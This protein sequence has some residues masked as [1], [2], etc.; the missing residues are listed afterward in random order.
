MATEKTNIAVPR[1]HVSGGFDLIGQSWKIFIQKWKKLFWFLLFFP[2][3][4]F[5]VSAAIGA[6]SVWGTQYLE[7][8]SVNAGTDLAIQI[9]M[10]VMYVALIVAAVFFSMVLSAATVYVVAEDLSPKEAFKKGIPVFWRFFGWI[11]LVSIILAIAF[12]LLVVPAIILIVFLWFSV[13]A[14]T[15]EGLGPIKAMGRSF[16]LV[17]GF[18]WT[19]FARF[20]I[21][22]IFVAILSIISEALSSGGDY[23][24]GFMD[25]GTGFLFSSVIIIVLVYVLVF[26]INFIA[27]SIALIYSYLLYK[28]LKEIKS[29]D[30]NSTDRM[31][32]SKKIGLGFIMVAIIALIVIVFVAIAAFTLSG[33]NPN[34]AATST[35]LLLEQNFNNLDQAGS[36]ISQEQMKE[37]LK[38]LETNKK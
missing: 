26:I 15:L 27:N 34:S 8:G 31:P 20:L 6:L 38:Q 36:V 35:D 2:A 22:F 23:L 37:V 16:G 9:A 10:G 1:I 21:L 12:L 28:R 29:A 30:A 3:V 18:W 11:I 5:G 33:S 32:V 17:S 4:L 24:F 25:K 14:I 19:L 7:L 13:F